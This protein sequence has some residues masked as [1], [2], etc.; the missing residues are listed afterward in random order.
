[1]HEHLREQLSGV[2]TIRDLEAF[3]SGSKALVWRGLLG[4]SAEPGGLVE[5]VRRLPQLVPALVGFIR[6]VHFHLAPADCAARLRRRVE[7]ALAASLRT[8]GG[9]VAAFQDEG[10]QYDPRL[11]QEEPVVV[12]CSA[13]APIHGLPAQFEA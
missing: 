1:M 3:C 12:S 10:V 11:P 9:Q 5:Y 4:S 7:A 13:A 2:Y 8:Q 6:A